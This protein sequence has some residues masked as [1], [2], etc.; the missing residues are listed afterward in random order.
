MKGF[1]EGRVWALERGLPSG[2]ARKTG[3]TSLSE[4]VCSLCPVCKDL[5]K[6]RNSPCME[7]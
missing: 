4:H 3:Q 5:R 1:E 2:I 6:C 7:K